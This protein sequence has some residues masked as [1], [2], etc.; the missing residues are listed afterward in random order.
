M[1][2]VSFYLSID[3]TVFLQ[4]FI[5]YPCFPSCCAFFSWE[6]SSADFVHLWR[7][8]RTFHF[9]NLIAHSFFFGDSTAKGQEFRYKHRHVRG[10]GQKSSPPC[11][12]SQKKS[13]S[14]SV[15]V[16]SHQRHLD[17]QPPI[18]SHSSTCSIHTT[19]WSASFMASGSNTDPK[20]VCTF[21]SATSINFCGHRA[22]IS[23]AF[24]RR[25]HAR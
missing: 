16:V 23:S 7:H 4:S 25:Q 11:L 14:A 22:F 3:H 19:S 18:Y 2:N 15:S 13:P 8:S 17:K 24:H 1:I 21:S 5:F 20:T 10:A 6:T 12:L 9:F